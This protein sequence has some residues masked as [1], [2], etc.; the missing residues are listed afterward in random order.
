MIK[1]VTKINQTME[2]IRNQIDILLNNI[3]KEN[4][5]SRGGDFSINGTHKKG[6][7]ANTQY[8]AD[9]NTGKESESNVPFIVYCKRTKHMIAFI[10]AF[11]TASIPLQIKHI[12]KFQATHLGSGTISETPINSGFESYR[13]YFTLE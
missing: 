7:Y 6:Y 10:T 9:I 1:T 5:F 13:I 8:E 12:D 4:G 11:E 2:D 3:C